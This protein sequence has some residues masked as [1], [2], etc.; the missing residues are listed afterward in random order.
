MATRPKLC[1]NQDLPGITFNKDS[2]IASEADG[3]SK[4]FDLSSVKFTASAFSKSKITLKPEQ[5]ARISQSD[6]TDTNGYVKLVVIKVQYPE[7][8]S[9]PSGP[10]IPGII[11]PTSGTPQIKK[12]ITWEYE[13]N[14]FYVGE[15][16]ILTGKSLGSTNSEASGWNMTDQNL[17]YNYIP[18]GIIL[19][20][21]HTNITVKIEVLLG[22]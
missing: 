19:T 15:L 22:R 1:A 16:M 8:V 2:V 7:P 10:T 18:G 12:Y 21:P 14:V 4:L 9:T 3:I 20:N 13:G 17:P 6:I 11:Q 5:S